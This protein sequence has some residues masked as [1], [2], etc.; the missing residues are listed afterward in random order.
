[1][2]SHLLV[3]VLAC[4][5]LKMGPDE[6]T[7][8]SLHHTGFRVLGRKIIQLHAQDIIHQDMGNR[9]RARKESVNMYNLP[10]KGKCPGKI[11]PSG[12]S[13]EEGMGVIQKGDE[14]KPRGAGS[15]RK[16]PRWA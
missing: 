15:Q 14:L 10:G 13:A 4:T 11:G 2:D 5:S 9:G 7:F 6:M 1:M 3:P 8:G 16:R 12:A